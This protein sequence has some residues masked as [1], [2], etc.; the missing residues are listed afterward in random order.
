MFLRCFTLLFLNH[1]L[2]GSSQWEKVGGGSGRDWLGARV[3]GCQLQ[4]TYFQLEFQQQRNLHKFILFLQTKNNKQVYQN[5][6]GKKLNPEQ[7]LTCMWAQMKRN[8]SQGQRSECSSPWPSPAENKRERCALSSHCVPQAAT[9]SR[10]FW[11]RPSL[12]ADSI[13]VSH[14]E[15]KYP[16]MN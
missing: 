1:I 8:K 2:F 10:G 5:W 13:F 4:L 15:L 7:I 16:I 6:R 9:C 12:V 11:A 14:I 3:L